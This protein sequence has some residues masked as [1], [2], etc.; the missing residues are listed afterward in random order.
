MC[1]SSFL[2]YYVY[3]HH[4]LQYTIEVISTSKQKLQSPFVASF[5]ARPEISKMKGLEG[6]K[7]AKL[8]LLRE[9][10]IPLVKLNLNLI[11]YG[12]GQLQ[13]WLFSFPGTIIEKYSICCRGI[14][15]SIGF[16]DLLTFLAFE[17]II[18]I[19]LQALV[20]WIFL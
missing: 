2:P 17:R 7:L 13:K 8:T 15:F 5:T 3:I 16:K 11:Y 14:L 18:L 4:A 19:G 10:W 12:W 20:L 9:G 6:L 1:S